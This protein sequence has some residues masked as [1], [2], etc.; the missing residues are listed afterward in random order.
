LRLIYGNIFNNQI[1]I[2]FICFNFRYFV[3]TY[4]KDFDSEAVYEEVKEDSRILPE[5]DG[6][7]LVKI[8]RKDDLDTSNKSSGSEKKYQI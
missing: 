6:K 4:N 1:Y 2:Y 7:V 3:K 5:Y 8:E